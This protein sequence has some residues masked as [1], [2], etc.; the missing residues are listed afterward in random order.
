MNDNDLFSGISFED[1]PAEDQNMSFGDD[2]NKE[3]DS[4]FSEDLGQSSFLQDIYDGTNTGT[5]QDMQDHEKYHSQNEI[6]EEVQ[7]SIRAAVLAPGLTQTE[8]ITLAKDGLQRLHST[9]RKLR[10]V[11]NV[12]YLR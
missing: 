3:L 8:R 12:L 10:D 4:L 9:G 11:K 1:T 2:L 6:L 7:A 5:N